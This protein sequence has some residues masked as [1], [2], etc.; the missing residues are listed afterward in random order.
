M[1]QRIQTLYIFIVIVLQSILL[2]TN[3]AKCVDLSSGNEIIYK[4][5]DNFLIAA[6]TSL[7]ALIPAISMFLYKKRILQMRFNIFNS[8][9][10]VALQGFIV[11]YIVSYINSETSSVFM[12]QSL[13]PVISL[14]LS[15]LAIRNI[16]KDELLIRSLHRLR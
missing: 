10:L 2:S 9:L 6:L 16:L 13:F 15:I 1:I 7:T 8:I 12:I 4:T 11:Y 5:M 3:I 14:I